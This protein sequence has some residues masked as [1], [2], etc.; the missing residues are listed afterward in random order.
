VGGEGHHLLAPAPPQVRPRRS[1]A[2]LAADALAHQ[3]EQRRIGALRPPMSVE[4]AKLVL[5]R[6]GRTVYRAS[7]I[8]GPADR[9]KV[10]G[11]QDPIDDAMLKREA[12]RLLE[13]D[14]K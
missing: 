4:E 12:E 8:G 7:V 11:F 13:R 2:E 6:K 5:Q 9:W 1:D 3:A 14:G 10:S